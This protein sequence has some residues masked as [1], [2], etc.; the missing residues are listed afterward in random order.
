MDAFLI[1][2]MLCSTPTAAYVLNLACEHGAQRGLDGA[3]GGG[4]PNLKHAVIEARFYLII[5]SVRRGTRAG[6]DPA[7]FSWLATQG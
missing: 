7:S 5:H 2:N 3:N 6:D 4:R 1:N